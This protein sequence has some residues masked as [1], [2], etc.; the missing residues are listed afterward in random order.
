MAIGHDPAL[1]EHNLVLETGSTAVHTS[2]R[3][4]SPA[5]INEVSSLIFINLVEEMWIHEPD[6]YRLGELLFSTSQA[7]RLCISLVF[8]PQFESIA[9]IA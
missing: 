3:W 4:R 2:Q 6:S 5:A 8:R 1:N 9:R 7:A